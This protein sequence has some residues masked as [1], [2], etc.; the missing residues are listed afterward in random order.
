MSKSNISTSAAAKKRS[1]DP[2]VVEFYLKAKRDRERKEK[3]KFAERRKVRN[4]GTSIK[5]VELMSTAELYVSPLCFSVNGL[6]EEGANH[7]IHGPPGSM[8]TTV[9]A[10]LLQRKARGMDL[11]SSPNVDRKSVVEG[12]RG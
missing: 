5:P 2:K 12:K 10:D 6:I 9:V 3:E 1:L 11:T 8:K 7:V 4:A